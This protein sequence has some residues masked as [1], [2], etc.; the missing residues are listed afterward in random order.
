MSTMPSKCSGCGR[1]VEAL[2]GAGALCR[3]CAPPGVD[4][5][6]AAD[7]DPRP[8]RRGKAL[9][10]RFNDGFKELASGGDR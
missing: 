2:M 7:E 5:T 6:V 4:Y 10:Q 3:S 8:H 9:Q 1:H